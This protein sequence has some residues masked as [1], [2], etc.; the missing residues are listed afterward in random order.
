MGRE[1]KTQ[2]VI[3][4]S[5]ELWNRMRWCTK[6]IIYKNVKVID[7]DKEEVNKQDVDKP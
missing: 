4:V 5:R 1:S 2:D 3:H 6:R 7:N